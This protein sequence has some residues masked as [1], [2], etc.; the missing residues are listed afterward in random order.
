MQP[1]DLAFVLLRRRCP[2]VLGSFISLEVHCLWGLGRILE[3][4]WNKPQRAR[5]VVRRA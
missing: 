3:E 1:I 4:G 5:V 2:L